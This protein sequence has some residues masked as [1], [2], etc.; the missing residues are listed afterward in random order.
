MVG[1][2]IVSLGSISDQVKKSMGTDE[3]PY[4]GEVSKEKVYEAVLKLI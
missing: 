4:E 3:E 2:K 1:G